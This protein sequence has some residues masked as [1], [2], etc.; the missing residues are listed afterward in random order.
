M[1]DIARAQLDYLQAVLG[2][3]HRADSY[4]SL[5][6]RPTDDGFRFFAMCSD[7]FAWG[8][9]DC[10]RIEP[11][12]VP[13]LERC[14]NDLKA[15][16]PVLGECDLPELFAARKRGMRPMR[17]FLWPKHGRKDEGWPA[18]RELFLAAGPE[19]DIASEG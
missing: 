18:V 1:H 5:M 16:D 8:T 12:D 6:W 14:L 11:A 19:R 15:A 10:E 13:L 3:F 4:Q 7:T 9:A 17:L 2:V